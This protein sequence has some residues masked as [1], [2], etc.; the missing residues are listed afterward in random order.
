M[1]CWS[2]VLRVGTHTP[3]LQKIVVRPL[4]FLLRAD[5]LRKILSKNK[6][7]KPCRNLFK[8]MLNLGKSGRANTI[9]LS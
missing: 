4:T 5:E 1:E 6:V 3:F 7:D 9:F 8:R 2:Y